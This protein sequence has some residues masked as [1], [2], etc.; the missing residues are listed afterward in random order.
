MP[1][2][3]SPG[4]VARSSNASA[5]SSASLGSG[6]GT[7]GSGWTVGGGSVLVSNS[8]VVMSTPEMPSTRAW[9]VLAISANRSPARRLTREISHSGLSRSSCWENSRPHS[10]RSCSSLP[11]RGSAVLRTW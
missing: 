3:T 9:C 1:R 8:T 7:Q 10:L 2:N 11:G 6:R 4:T 5:S